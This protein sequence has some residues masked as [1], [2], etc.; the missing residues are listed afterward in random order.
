[1]KPRDTET[2]LNYARRIPDDDSVPLAFEKRVMARLR[3]E[4]A[5]DPWTLWLPLLWRSAV[6]CLMVSLCTGVLGSLVREPAQPEVLASHL[7]QVV[8][9]PLVLDEEGW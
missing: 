3:R 6:A 8:Y 9:A 2:F 4:G 5:A 7:E 1:M